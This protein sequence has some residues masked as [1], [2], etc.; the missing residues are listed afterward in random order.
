[1]PRPRCHPDQAAKQRAYRAR[2][3]LA[4]AEEHAAKGLPPSPAVATL[5]GERRWRALLARAQAALETVRDEMEAYAE[6][7]SES[8]QES[9]RAELLR[10]RLRMLEEVLESLEGLGP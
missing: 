1:M 9:D 4:R 7:R 5:P 8:W 2:V 6:E 10:D 3:A